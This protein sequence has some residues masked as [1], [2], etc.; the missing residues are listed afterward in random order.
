MLC[1]VYKSRKK[2]DTYLFIERRDDFS[3]VPDALRQTFGPGQ[4]VMVT[5]LDPAKP[6]G[7][8]DV[9]KVMAALVAQGFYLQLPPPQENLL[10]QHK[11]SLKGPAAQS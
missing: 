9:E 11:A 5:K 10:E 2:A 4:L 8:S 7:I 1:A 6:L 3:R